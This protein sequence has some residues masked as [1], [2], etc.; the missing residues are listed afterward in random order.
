[1]HG[2]D[3]WGS[4]RG[5]ADGLA[6]RLKLSDLALHQRLQPLRPV[7]R[8]LFDLLEQLRVESLCPPGLQGVA[9]NLRHRFTRWSLGFQ[10]ARHTDGAR[11]LL[12]YTV[13]Q[14]ARARIAGEP[15]LEQTEDLIEATRAAMAPVL[16]AELDGLRR[17]RHDQAAFARHALALAEIVDGLLQA[18][19]PTQGPGSAGLAPVDPER[20]A[21]GWLLDLDD[22]GEAQ[23]QGSS[24]GPGGLR[25][26]AAGPTDYR[27]YTRRYDRVVE[28]PAL[29]RRDELRELRAELDRRVQAAALP[30]GRLAGELQRLLAPP[31]PAGWRGGHDEGLLDGRALARL[32]ATPRERRLF[33]RQAPQPRSDAVLGVLLD[34]SGSMRAQ[35]QA[36]APLLDVLMCA[37]ELAGVAGELLGFSTGAWQGGRAWRDWQ[38]AGRPPRPGRL[39]EQCHIV[40]KPADMPWRRARPGI[41]ALLKPEIYREGLDGEAVDWAVARLAARA[42]PHKL[43]LVLGDG[44]P[45]DRATQLAN[46][47]A[48]LDRHLLQVL[49][50]HERDGRVRIGGLG[51]GV[52]LS[53]FHAHHQRLEAGAAPDRHTLRQVLALIA[54]LRGRTGARPS[55]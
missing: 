1:V 16:G 43:L 24:A 44:C 53:A 35:M 39:N 8:L 40:F 30:R 23:G 28:A 42:E 54:R 15:A 49:Q 6:L 45:M 46:D 38:R 27:V 19:N 29:V 5:A 31:V 48:L 32:V 51:A 3:D 7:P 52:D 11:G 18:A 50:R 34:C 13:A 41:A 2:L 14:M 4:F 25:A 26:S 21:F 22:P 55:I 47:D 36:L 10:A 33:L 12:L 20:E 17:Q 9:G 37:L